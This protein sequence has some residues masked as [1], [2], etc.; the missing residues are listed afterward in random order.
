MRTDIL[1]IN[2]KH[3][4]TVLCKYVLLGLSSRFGDF[5]PRPDWTDFRLPI[6]PLVHN[7]LY[8]L[9][10]LSFFLYMNVLPVYEPYQGGLTIF[11]YFEFQDEIVVFSL[12]SLSET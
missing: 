12:M 9:A 11:D 5:T 10:C 2:N 8:H 6:K 4:L 1:D 7:H 3:R